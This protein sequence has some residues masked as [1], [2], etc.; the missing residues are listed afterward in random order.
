MLVAMKKKETKG[1]DERIKRI[2]IKPALI[3]N[4]SL[5]DSFETF[6]DMFVSG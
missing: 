6:V 4:R 1:L 5:D 2:N 3:A